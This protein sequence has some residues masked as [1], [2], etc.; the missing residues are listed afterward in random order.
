MSLEERMQWAAIAAIIGALHDGAELCTERRVFQ[1][2]VAA[3]RSFCVPAHHFDQVAEKLGYCYVRNGDY[4]AS[5]ERL[6]E[7]LGTRH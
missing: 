2:L 1:R 5:K 7:H 3:C 6:A 4:Y